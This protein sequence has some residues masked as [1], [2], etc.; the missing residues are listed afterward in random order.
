MLDRADTAF[1]VWYPPLK[2]ESKP[3]YHCTDPAHQDRNA[4]CRSCFDTGVCNGYVQNDAIPVRDVRYEEVLQVEEGPSR[5]EDDFTTLT[6]ECPLGFH[7]MK[8]CIFLF[9]DRPWRVTDVKQVDEDEDDD[10]NEL[11]ER[12]EVWCRKLEVWEGA[13]CFLQTT[14]ATC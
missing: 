4:L 12:W 13:A 1:E 11:P 7:I 6:F 10:G 14:E 2:Q 5:W 8:G 9:D 3:E